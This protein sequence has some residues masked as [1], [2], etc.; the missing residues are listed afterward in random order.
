MSVWT[1][2]KCKLKASVEEWHWRFF[3]GRSSVLQ[4]TDLTFLCLCDKCHLIPLLLLPPAL[5]LL[6]FLKSNNPLHSFPF[7][8][9]RGACGSAGGQPLQAVAPPA[10]PRVPLPQMHLHVLQW[11]GPA[12]A[13][14]EARW[15]QALPVPALLLRQQSTEPARGASTPRA[16]GQWRRTSCFKE[17]YSEQIFAIWRGIE[18]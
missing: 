7:S 11:P 9:T 4:V 17:Q 18:F 6:P 13:P 14:A 1:K 2:L 12:A 10:G 8:S 3:F 5:Q 15:D 16:Q